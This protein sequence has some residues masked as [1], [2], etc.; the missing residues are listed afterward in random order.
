MGWVHGSSM[1]QTYVHLS[2]KEQDRAVLRAYGMIKNENQDDEPRP[3]K[4]PKCGE[5]NALSAMKCKKCWLPLDEKEIII[6]QDLQR[7]ADEISAIIR[8]FTNVGDLKKLMDLLLQPEYR[9]ILEEIGEREIS[10][11]PK[12]KQKFWLGE[13]DSMR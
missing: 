5:I 2:A 7:K 3:K 8:A 4:C 1:M 10:K 13:T 9:K 11:L 12:E 6:Q